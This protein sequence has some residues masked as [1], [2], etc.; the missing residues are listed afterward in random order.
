MLPKHKYLLTYR[1]AEIVNDLNVEFCNI[2]VNKYSR[3]NDQMIQAGRSAKQNIVEGVGQS[4]ISKK[5]EIKLLGVAEASIEELTADY[6]DFLRQKKLSIWD[7]NDPR[8][9]RFRNL[10]M[11]STKTYPPKSI[12]LPDSAEET[13]NLLL[14]LCHQLTFLLDKQINSLEKKFVEEGGFS[15]NLLRKRLE[16]RLPK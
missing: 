3:T 15:E 2:F 9:R 5:G 14:T 7:K 11:E 4:R 13:A 16:H 10:G 12:K 8:I 6:E 1:F